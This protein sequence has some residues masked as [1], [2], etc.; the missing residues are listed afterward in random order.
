MPQSNN[1]PWSL[2][3]SLRCDEICRHF[4]KAWLAGEQPELANYLAENPDAPRRMLFRELLLLE[5]TF[6]KLGNEPEAYADY[7]SRF[8]DD[9]DWIAEAWSDESSLRRSL[10]TT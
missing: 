2:D 9:A 8:P 1:E 4:E 7:Q 6:L 5:K 3:A 10:T